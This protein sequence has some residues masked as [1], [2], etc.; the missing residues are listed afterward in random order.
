MKTVTY[1]KEK[2]QSIESNCNLGQ[3]LN[4]AS[5]DNKE[6]INVFKELTENILEDLKENLP[7]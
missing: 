1:S 6:V 4:L 7:A 3:M 2:R 5:K